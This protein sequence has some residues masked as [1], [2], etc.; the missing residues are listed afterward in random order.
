MLLAHLIRSAAARTFCTAARSSDM[1]M[2]I[3]A[4]TTR[5]SMSVN[6]RRVDTG[7]G[8]MKH[9]RIF[10]GEF[11]VVGEEPATGQGLSRLRLKNPKTIF[12]RAAGKYKGLD[13]RK[14]LINAVHRCVKKRQYA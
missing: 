6:A 1:M 3:I 12:A 14:P 8:R 13:A 11:R 4:I 5:S 9:P 7:R 2:P 10:W